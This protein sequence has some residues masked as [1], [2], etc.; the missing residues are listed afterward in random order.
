MA[1]LKQRVHRMNSSGSYDTVHYETQASLVLYTNNSQSNVSGALDKLFTDMS[2]KAASSH[3]HAASNITSGT[4]GVARGGTGASTLTSGSY[5]LGNG[6]SAV[7]FKTAAQV[8]SH[9]GHAASNHTHSGY[10][11]VAVGT[12]SSMSS[13]LTCSFDVKAAIVLGST[14]YGN[15]GFCWAVIAAGTKQ[16][17]VSSSMSSTVNLSSNSN[18]VISGQTVSGTVYIYHG[19][20]SSKYTADAIIAFG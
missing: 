2:G 13:S 5:I 16:Y 12:V 9:I 7:Q 17:L 8:L 11:N 19:N 15:S 20:N 14:G 6:T 3:N 10:C 1:T 18:A 4:L